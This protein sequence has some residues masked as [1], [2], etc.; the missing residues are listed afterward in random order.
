MKQRIK[1]IYA[2]LEGKLSADL[3]EVLSKDTAGK[4]LLVK[5]ISDGRTFHLGQQII[6]DKDGKRDYVT[7]KIISFLS[8]KRNVF[9]EDTF[10]NNTM[11]FSIDDLIAI[12]RDNVNGLIWDKDLGWE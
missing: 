3:F 9:I 10:W 1:K 5:R 7:W 6:I 12:T 11:T 8:D 2:W 4:A